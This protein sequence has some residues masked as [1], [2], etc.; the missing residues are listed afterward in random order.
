VEAW[1]RLTEHSADR[2][3]LVA[4]QAVDPKDPVCA[5]QGPR[6]RVLLDRH[7]ETARRFNALWLPRAYAL[8]AE[9][10][11]TYVQPAAT[12]DPRAPLQVTALWG[13]TGPLAVAQDSAS[14]ARRLV[15][16]LRPSARR[17]EP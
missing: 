14:P 13:R 12:L 7:G 16:A 11:L 1:S 3:L 10:R 5:K 15:A 8:D 2:I 6:V 17:A 9:G 4:M